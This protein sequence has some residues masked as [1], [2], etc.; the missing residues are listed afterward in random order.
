MNTE[1]NKAIVSRV[2]KEYIEGGNVNTVYE[3]FAPDFI[4]QTAPPGS[5]Q[6]P[7]AI[8]YFFDQILRP[9]FPDLKVVIH[10][11]V[12][13]GDKVSTRKSFHATHKGNFF[14]VP[15]TN[16]NVVMDV[17]DIIRLKNGKYVEHWGILD[18][19]GLMAQLTAQ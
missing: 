5:P 16:K 18:T 9:A 19:Q 14:G 13:E 1:Q 2:N 10:D 17:I 6:G 15:A 7:E 4:N 12:A 11:Q 8:I 3:I